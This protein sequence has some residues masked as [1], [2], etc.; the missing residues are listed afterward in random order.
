MY[1]W[2]CMVVRQQCKLVINFIYDFFDKNAQKLQPS[3]GKAIFIATEAE[4]MQHSI[5]VRQM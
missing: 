5:V 4:V 3:S 2:R 1:I